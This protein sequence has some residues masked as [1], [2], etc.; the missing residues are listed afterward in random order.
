MRLSLRGGEPHTKEPEMDRITALKARR[1]GLIEKMEALVAGIPDGED[2]TGEQSVELDAL[3]AQDDKLAKEIDVAEDLERRKASAARPIA[4]LPSNAPLATVPAAPAEKGIRFARQLRALAAANGSAFVAA[5]IAESW[6]DSGLFANQ[7]MGQGSAGGFLVPEDVSSEIIEL[8]RPASVIMASQPVVVPMPNGNLTMNRLTQGAAASYIGEQQDVPATDVKFG[9][10][11]L[12]AKK[13]AALIPITNDLLRAASVAVDRI[14]RDDV[15]TEMSLKMD[16]AFI[17]GAGGD[18]SP[19]G[20]RSQLVGTSVATTNI[21]TMTA[22]QN[23][24]NITT[25]LGRLEL[26]LLNADVPMTRAVWLMAPRTMMALQNIRDGNGNFAFPEVQ[27][28]SLRGKPIRVTNHIPINLGGGSDSELYLVDFAHV[29][30]GEHMGIQVAMSTEAAYRDAGNNLQAAFSLDQTIV[31]TIMQ[32][33]I[34]LRHLPA[35]AI[36]TGVTWAA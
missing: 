17:R 3:R 33:D 19:L 18:H 24:A 36:L 32:H 30:V 10:L 22:T 8:L 5:Q 29:V 31:R 9:Q 11:K 7:N 27:Q 35:V 14:V 1:A 28:G 13:L 4:P 6:G 12:S 26:A 23:L 16:R 2:L 15:V 25:D 34:G 21:L 20:L